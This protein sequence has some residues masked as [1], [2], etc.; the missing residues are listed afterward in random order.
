MAD[1]TDMPGYT[2]MPNKPSP[3]GPKPLGPKTPGYTTLPNKV[4][5]GAGDFTKPA[6]NPFTP[7]QG[8]RPATPADRGNN[9]NRSVGGGIASNL[10]N[11]A[12]GYVTNL[13]RS[14][15]DVPTA[16]GTALDSRGAMARGE[17]L[18]DL[19]QT[20]RKYGLPPVTPGEVKSMST[21]PI[22]NLATQ[23]GQVAK[24]VVGIK[25]TDRSKQNYLKSYG[26]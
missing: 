19:N 9:P 20:K 3:G 13:G 16:L 10:F 14:V 22:K 4:P 7:K 15:R 23:V 6:P 8:T 18:S 12:K 2:T 11:S 21:M 17:A 1:I 5:K 26:K 25:D 24:S